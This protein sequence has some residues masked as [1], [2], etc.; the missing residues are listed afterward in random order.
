MSLVVVFFDRRLLYLLFSPFHVKRMS[1]AFVA[2]VGA[3]CAAARRRQLRGPAAC[4]RRAAKLLR[5][6]VAN[7][8]HADPCSLIAD[9]RKWGAEMQAAAPLGEWGFDF[10]FV[11]SSGALAC[12]LRTLLDRVM[13]QRSAK[14]EQRPWHCFSFRP[15]DGGPMPFVRFVSLLS[16]PPPPPKTQHLGKKQSSPSATWCAASSTLSER[17]AKKSAA[18][19][20]AARGTR[21]TPLPTGGCRRRSRTRRRRALAAATAAAAA[22]LEEEH[23]E[24]EEAAAAPTPSPRGPAASSPAP[25]ARAAG[26][27]RC[28][29]SSTTKTAS[30]GLEEREQ[31]E[32]PKESSPLPLRCRPWQR[33]RLEAAAA[34]AGSPLPRS[35]RARGERRRRRRRSSASPGA[36]RPRSC[37][38]G[39]GGPK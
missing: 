7:G 4:A 22:A 20:T 35:C 9:V 31:A 34:A 21:G 37:P 25:F 12:L 11:F 8:R 2:E 26:T 24:E 1:A 17:K 5:L 32:E 18:A 14:K 13:Q 30:W 19:G 3:F 29:T 15:I 28:T 33:Q 39:R 23:Q 38:P 6:L 10:D 16:Q 27:S 36:A